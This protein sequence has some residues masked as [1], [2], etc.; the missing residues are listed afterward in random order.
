MRQASVRWWSVAVCVMGASL[1]C[2]PAAP[3]T[4][5]TS[6]ADGVTVAQARALAKNAYVYGYGPVYMERQRRNRVSADTDM[7]DGRAPE[8]TFSWVRELATPALKVIVM[9]NND[10]L[11]GSA[12]LDLASGP[13]LLDV[14]DMGSR[15][16][17][18][19]FMDAFSNTF[20]YVGS[21][22]TGARAGT[23]AIVGP[24]EAGTVPPGVSG[25]ITA[26]TRRVWIAARMGFA[27]P[28]ELDA[29]HHLQDAVRLTRADGAAI[30][31]RSAGYA[32]LPPPE[33]LPALD[34]FTMLGDVLREYPA[35]AAAA[36]LQRT[37]A[38]IGLTAT[39]FDSTGLS[40]EVKAAMEAGAKDGFAAIEGA[41]LGENVNG[42]D[43]SLKNGRFGE[44]YLLRSAIAYR[45]LAGN[46]PEEAIYFNADKDVD[47]QGLSGAHR[48]E[49]RFERGQLPPVGA[50]GSLTMYDARDF[51]LVENAIA[52]Y[53]IGSQTKGLQTAADGSVTVYL[54][55]TS[56]GAG[57]A[58]NWLPSPEGAF[59]VHLRAYVP[60]PSLLDGTYRLPPL[61]RVG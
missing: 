48:Y 24:G 11:Y 18:F 33:R 50:V 7:G 29:V 59:D 39:G 9:P 47:G 13:L 58:A 2:G 6:V 20:A 53:S 28:E 44:D 56:P 14:P 41:T 40:A 17:T 23:F 45:S 1:A 26:P 49:L 15:Y 21:R 27:G 60:K 61:K 8:N 19:Q 3:L 22:A 43:F 25:T 52:R 55:A 46:A 10:T 32:P 37:W 16:F 31:R 42:W 51:L 5:A 38:P 12:W 34:V 57:K 35:P 4:G 54:Q 36:A 30:P